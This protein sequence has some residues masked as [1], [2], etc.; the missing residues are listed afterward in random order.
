MNVK[1]ILSSALALLILL[2][3]FQ[4]AMAEPGDSTAPC[5]AEHVHL[6]GCGDVSIY[7][8][9]MRALTALMARH[10]TPNLP[11]IP[12]DEA[13][14]FSRSMRKVLEPAPIYDSPGGNVIGNLPNGFV[15]LSAGRG[16]N[17]WVQIAP[18]QFVQDS[19]LGPVN[20]AISR[21]SGVLLP[22]SFP[23]IPFAWI[24]QDT[25]PSRTPGARPLADTPR[26]PRYT[27]VNIFAVQVV[28][29]WEWY[30]IGPDQ[31][32]LQ[33][34]V[35]KVKPAA[36]PEGVS[37]KWFAVDLYEQT[38]VAYIDDA[39]VFATLI[40]SGLQMW[41]TTEGVHQIMTRYRRAPMTG[42]AGEPEYW[43]LPNV[44]YILY[45]TDTDQAL[46]GAYWH[47]GFGYRRSRGCV[48]LSITDARWAYEWTEDAPNAYVY[49]YYSGVYRPNAPQ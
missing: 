15:F 29:T 11:Q 23:E 32:V 37:G 2:A 26:V 27:L 10:P 22:N 36:R 1:R 24:L 30:L 31:W 25:R 7:G 34:Q 46:H 42:A 6:P 13:E 4:P 16:A 14:L 8:T 20:A 28:D 40:A 5:A 19:A 21:L 33:T 35:A 39:P 48:N 17:G 3:G 41:S 45:F 9:E 38:M 43:Y 47:D 49:I 12:V 18:G 44:P